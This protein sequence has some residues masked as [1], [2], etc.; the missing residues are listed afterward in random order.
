LLYSVRTMHPNIYLKFTGNDPSNSSAIELEEL[1]VSLTGF[2]TVFKDIAKLSHI[3]GALSVETANI[4]H[5]SIIFEI[6]LHFQLTGLPFSDPRHLLD[7]L[8]VADHDL[9][10]AAQAALT[11]ERGLDAFYRDHPFASQVASQGFSFMVGRFYAEIITATRQLKSSFTARLSTGVEIPHGYIG[12]M[13]RMIERGSYKK[14]L[15]PF[16]DD[17]VSKIEIGTIADGIATPLQ[18]NNFE[19]YLG[20]GEK[21]LPSLVNGQTVR[22][23]VEITAIQSTRGESVTLKLLSRRN[24]HVVGLPGDGLSSEDYVGWYKKPAL[25]VGE[26]FRS[27]LYQKPKII[28]HSLEPLQ[29]EMEL[30]S[31]DDE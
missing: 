27:S 21:V 1:L 24:F 22:I 3:E 4:Q 2:N 8:S 28:I 11:T 20:E 9:F 14:A 17:T 30:T 5:G 15:K 10:R 26:V 25:V 19:E 16:V 31:L 18:Q 13:K 6:A 7:F 29:Q 23:P 12:P